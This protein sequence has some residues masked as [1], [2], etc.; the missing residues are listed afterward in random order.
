MSHPLYNKI[1]VKRYQE[2]I[3]YAVRDEIK[4]RAETGKYIIRG[5]GYSG[6]LPDFDDLLL[7]PVHGLGTRAPVDQY[8]E[9][10]DTTVV[11]GKGMVKKPLKLATPILIGA[12]SYGATSR[13]FKLACAKA[14]NTVGTATN[15]GEGGQVMEKQPDGSIKW[16]EF[17]YSKPNGYLVVQFA[18][19]R[20]GVSLEYLV[21][22]DAIE[23]KYGQGAKPG[24]GGHLLGEKVLDEIA[25]TRGIPKGTD[26]LSPARHLDIRSLDDLKKIIKVLRDIVGYEKPIGIKLGPGNVYKEVYTAAQC[27]IDFIAVDGKYGGTGASPQHAIQGL[28]LPTLACIPAA[29]RALK[30]AGVRENVA[31][32]ALGGFRDG[33]DVA[34]ALALGADAV[35]L[36][37]AIEIAAG[38]IMCGQC[39]TGKCPVGICTQD[40]EL[41]KKIGGGKGIDEAAKWIANYMKAVTKEIA[42][43]AAACGHKS[44]REFNKEDLRAIT[45][46]AAAIAGVKLAGLEDY[47]L[48]QWK[49]F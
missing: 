37:S 35:A 41:R 19:G 30:D 43:L 28:G 40:P 45:I 42:Q 6:K 16:L 32:I 25:Y 3:Y 22:S 7:V 49:W 24:F 38:C 2:N 46:E 47:V 26:C 48:P 27:D 20:W 1:V 36:V 29:V 31:L 39:A 12:M 21:N 34:K 10:V 17:E 8:R 4:Y 11:I 5:F 15:S 9:K 13:E 44:V 14:A 33:V 18:S 23:V